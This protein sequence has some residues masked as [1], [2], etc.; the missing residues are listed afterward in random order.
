MNRPQ[1]ALTLFVAPAKES[2]AMHK[3]LR[4]LPL[5]ALAALA[6][7]DNK[8]TTIVAGGGPADPTANQIAAAP[9]VKLPPALLAT[10]SYRCKDNSLI[11][12]DWF[13]DNETANLHLKKK[14]GTPVHLEAPAAGQ[15]YVGQG[16]EL[17]GKADSGSV[18]FKTPGGSGQS[19][20]A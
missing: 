15:P 19:C 18:T 5:V 11:Y 12:I 20:D 10:K 8:P 6:A 16:Y 1:G 13:N 2:A 4:A 14:D 3:A 17:T 9:P 7:C